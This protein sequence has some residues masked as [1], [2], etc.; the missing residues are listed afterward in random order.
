MSTAVS[1]ATVPQLA[2]ATQIMKTHPHI[3][4][5]LRMKQDLEANFNIL[6]PLLEKYLKVGEPTSIASYDSDSYVNSSEFDTDV[7]DD[8]DILSSSSKII[9]KAADKKVKENAHNF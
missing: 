1:E 2:A 5:D 7:E 8:L 4:A 3:Q 6:V 9:R